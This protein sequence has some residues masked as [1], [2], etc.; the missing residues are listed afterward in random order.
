M[1]IK[2]QENYS[3]IYSEPPFLFHSVCVT[4]VGL[5]LCS[6]MCMIVMVAK[7]CPTLATLRTRARSLLCPWDF[8]GKTTGVGC[9]FLL[10]RLFLTQKSSPGL[11]HWQVDFLPLSHQGFPPMCNHR[12]LSLFQKNWIMVYLSVFWNLLSYNISQ[13]FLCQYMKISF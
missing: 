11:L 5:D 12:N 13:I 7:L 10:P 8:P 2:Q 9:H 1:L 6:F 4:A 3:K